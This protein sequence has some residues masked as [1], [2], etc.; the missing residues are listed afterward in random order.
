LLC[1][2]LHSRV[3]SSLSGPNIL[4]I[5]LF[6]KTLSLHFYLYVSDQVSQRLC[7]VYMSCTHCII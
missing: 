2:L 7:K 6:S 3:T 1:S 5:T 4:L